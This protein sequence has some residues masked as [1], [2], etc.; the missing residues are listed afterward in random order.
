[1]GWWNYQIDNT[2]DDVEIRENQ[3]GETDLRKY[4]ACGTGATVGGSLEMVTIIALTPTQ[5]KY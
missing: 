1:M 5:V 3:Q 2:V 4:V